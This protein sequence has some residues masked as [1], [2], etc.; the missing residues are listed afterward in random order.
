MRHPIG[1]AT[2]HHPQKTFEGE[3]YLTDDPPSLHP[4]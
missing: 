4:L 2:P 1:K 3:V